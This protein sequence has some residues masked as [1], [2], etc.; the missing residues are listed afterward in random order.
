MKRL[1]P[2]A[3]RL[4]KRI[5]AAVADRVLAF[6]ESADGSWL[7]GTRDALVV[8]RP[9]GDEKVVVPWELVQRARMSGCGRSAPAH[10]RRTVCRRTG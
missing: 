8:V 10:S 7:L 5:S 2:R 4:P 1:F 9:A 3:E 6:A